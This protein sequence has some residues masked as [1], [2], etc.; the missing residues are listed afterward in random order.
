VSGG[1]KVNSSFK[2]HKWLSLALCLIMVLTLTLGPVG[3]ALAEQGDRTPAT[4]LADEGTP[5]EPSLSVILNEVADEQ[6]ILEEF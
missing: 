5:H 3:L 2:Q 4:L 1:E 6:H